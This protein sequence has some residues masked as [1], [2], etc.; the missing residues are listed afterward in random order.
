MATKI[1]AI[2]EVEVETTLRN[3]STSAWTKRVL[4]SALLRPNP[5]QAIVDAELVVE[6]LRQALNAECLALSKGCNSDARSNQ[7]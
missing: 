3:P 2:A 7:T 1:F 4:E 6:T 5:F